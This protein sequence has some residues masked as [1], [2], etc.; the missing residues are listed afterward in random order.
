MAPVLYFQRMSMAMKEE[1]GKHINSWHTH[2][3]TFFITKCTFGSCCG[4]CMTR[5]S[6]R[7]GQ[8]ISP[9][10]GMRS[11]QGSIPGCLHAGRR[12]GI[13]VTGALCHYID[14]TR[15]GSQCGGP[16]PPKRVGG[17]RLLGEQVMSLGQSWIPHA[18]LPTILSDV[19][20]YHD[21]MY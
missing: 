7:P 11:M 14:H 15:R 16:H 17:S 5:S 18:S 6:G 9:A 2:T 8:G 4:S 20:G 3:Y 21:V 10:S 13:H 19:W 12:K 1:P